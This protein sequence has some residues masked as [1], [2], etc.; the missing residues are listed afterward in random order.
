MFL[1][2][3]IYDSKQNNISNLYNFSSN[4]KIISININNNNELEYSINNTKIGINV[5]TNDN[6]IKNGKIKLDFNKYIYYISFSSRRCNCNN[7]DG[8]ELETEIE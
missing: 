2:A 4:D 6:F 8:F 1:Y 7:C 3:S 5:S